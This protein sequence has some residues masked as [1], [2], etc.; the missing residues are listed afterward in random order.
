MGLSGLGYIV[1]GWVLGSEGFRQPTR[2]RSWPAMSSSWRGSFGWL[3][4]LGGQRNRSE[5]L[6][7]SKST[8]RQIRSPVLVDH[9]VAHPTGDH[10]AVHGEGCQKAKPSARARLAQE[11]TLL[12]PASVPAG[13]TSTPA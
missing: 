6:F 3:W 13:I 7:G 4:S 5:H 11:R 10:Q 9:R 2:S 8:R 12:R 1:Q